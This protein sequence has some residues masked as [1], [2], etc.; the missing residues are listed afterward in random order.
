[1]SDTWGAYMAAVNGELLLQL[2]LEG[3]RGGQR[4]RIS[5]EGAGRNLHQLLRRPDTGAPSLQAGNSMPH[6]LLA[7]CTSH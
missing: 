2:L 5:A 4:A 3:L 1:M 7:M 6:V